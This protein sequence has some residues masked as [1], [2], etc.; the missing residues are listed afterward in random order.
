[1]IVIGH[2][3]GKRLTLL[4]DNILSDSK[5]LEA[6]WLNDEQT[7]FRVNVL[8]KQISFVDFLGSLR[9]DLA[10]YHNVFKLPFQ[11]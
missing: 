8:Q 11:L 9:E 7:S 5:F 6:D 1:M 10:L 4:S 2:P 3:V